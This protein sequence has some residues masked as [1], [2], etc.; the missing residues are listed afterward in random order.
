MGD[1]LPSVAVVIPTY[2]RSGLLR[3][4]LEALASVDYPQATVVVVDD[5]SER[6]HAE[7]NR[8]EAE[9]LGMRYLFQENAGP[10]AARNRGIAATESE[11]VA[12]LDDDCAPAPDWLRRLVVPFTER[13]RERIGA[14]GGGVRSQPPHNWVSRFCAV[15]EYSTGVQ[16]VFTNAA[17]ANACFPRRVLDEVGGFDE[18]F[19]YPGG[20]DPDLSRR[21]SNAGYELRYLPEAVVFHAEIDS[22]R[23]FFEHVFRR[24]LGE[25]RLKQKERRRMR[26]LLRA[27]LLP[28]FILRR[29]GQTWRLAGGK[30][31]LVARI[32]Y[33]SLDGAGAA[34]FVCGTVVGLVRSDRP[35]STPPPP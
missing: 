5:G 24:G 33:A 20:D 27:A 35:G 18:G 32:A 19:R 13:D 26:L 3:R 7:R 1:T 8:I 16:P 30:A 10:A 11:L 21:I 23:D 9:R 29:A 15:A 6:L 4:S 31:A 22:F 28:L 14:A 25:A 2:N 12:F 17:T 34:V